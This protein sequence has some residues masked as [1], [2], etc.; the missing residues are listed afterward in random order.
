MA[1]VPLA[2]SWISVDDSLPSG[3]GREVS[4]IEIISDKVTSGCPCL[5]M[6]ATIFATATVF[7][8]VSP[9]GSLV[10]FVGIGVFFAGAPF[11]LYCGGAYCVW[12]GSAGFGIIFAIVAAMLPVIGMVVPWG[13]TSGFRLRRMKGRFI[14]LGLTAD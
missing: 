12:N 1:L 13:I 5:L 6:S 4:A 2:V 9:L 8:L 11:D 14:T 10:Q 7:L 3:V